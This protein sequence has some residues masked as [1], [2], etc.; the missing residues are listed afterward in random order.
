MSA[1]FVVIS[2][3]AIVE[4]D[5]EFDDFTIMAARAAL[6]KIGVRPALT[7]YGGPDV[8]TVADATKGADAV[9]NPVT[10]L[11]LNNPA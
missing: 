7:E 5:A 9:D 3:V 4:N 8:D 1:R 10:L 6:A 11:D 2:Y